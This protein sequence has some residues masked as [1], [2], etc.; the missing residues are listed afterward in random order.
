MTPAQGGP[1]VPDNYVE[2]LFDIEGRVAVVTGGGSGLGA[3][4]ATGFA[5]A[6]ARV[7]VVDINDAGAALTTATSRP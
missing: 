1:D 5:Q 7:I 4:I 2:D 3:A 6:G